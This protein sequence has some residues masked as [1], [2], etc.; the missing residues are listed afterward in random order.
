MGAA[1]FE[2]MDAKGRRRGW[3]RPTQEALWHPSE[4]EEA[5]EAAH[6]A[7]FDS[8]STRLGVLP[9]ATVVSLS[10]VLGERFE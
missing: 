4:A 9:A 7:L 3:R 6:C 8:E 1:E 5:E 10:C 2:M